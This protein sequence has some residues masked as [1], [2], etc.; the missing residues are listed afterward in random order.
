MRLLKDN[1]SMLLKLSD[2]GMREEYSVGI[3]EYDSDKVITYIK[4]LLD[5]NLECRLSV[6]PCNCSRHS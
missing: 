2:K 5:W 3:L 1:F 6:H 4:W